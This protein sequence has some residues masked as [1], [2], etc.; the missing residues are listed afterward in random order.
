MKEHGARPQRKGSL[1]QRPDCMEL[2]DR[3][4]RGGAAARVGRIPNGWRS[5]PLGAGCF[6]FAYRFF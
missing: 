4:G 1:R 6:G 3:A 5:Q 2:V